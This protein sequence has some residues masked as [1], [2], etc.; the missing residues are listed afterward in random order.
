M[1]VLTDETRV[2][3]AD[4]SAIGTSVRLVVTEASALTDARA[5][6]ER[7]LEAIDLACSRFRE[8]SELMLLQRYSAGAEVRVSPLLT[9]AMATALRAAA[10]TDGLVDPTVG[11][12]MDAVG[13]DRDF[14]T[15]TPSGARVRIVPVA[16]PGWRRLR[17]DRARRT[18]LVP[19]GVRVDLGATAK[20][21]V[22]DRAA[23]LVHEELGCGVLV[24]LGGDLA[25]GGPAPGSG[26]RVRVQD[27]TG[28]PDDAVVGQSS[29]VSITSGAIATS[30]TTGRRWVSG[31][32]QM[33]H[34][35]DP[36]TGL[37]VVSPWRTVSVSA[38][39]CVD[40]NTA[41]TAA[42]VRGASAPAWLESVGLPARLVAQDG[43]ILTVAGWPPDHDP[44]HEEVA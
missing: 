21:L 41:A 27:V 36:V 13:Y 33:H 26:W 20:A 43:S 31:G 25:V 37:P 2:A 3:A 14:V 7:E 40:A 19:R 30:S 8:D 5:L 11:A 6:L 38:A 1:D 32:R 44:A 4:W 42:L 16:A 9:E 17:V 12:S 22:A 35:V 24:D 29:V 10:L 34:I 39:T 18:V 23:R 28:H 15:I